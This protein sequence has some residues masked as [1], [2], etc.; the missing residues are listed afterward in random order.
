M[1]VSKRRRMTRAE[2]LLRKRQRLY[3][4][5]LKAANQIQSE[6]FEKEIKQIAKR[7]PTTRFAKRKKSRVKQPLRIDV[8]VGIRDLPPSS[9]IH[10][11]RRTASG[12]V[13]ARFRS[14]NYTIKGVPEHIFNDWIARKALARTEDTAKPKRWKKGAP[15][16]GA[17]FDQY[18]KGN[19][20]ILRGIRP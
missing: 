19:Y 2:Q 18:I 7:V 13:I 15:S 20:T 3:E 9:W 1:V 6:Y 5:T 10:S 17:Y 16:M 12:N 14:T 11:L 8:D 4:Q